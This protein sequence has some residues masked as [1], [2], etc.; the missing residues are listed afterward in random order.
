[1]YVS[2]PFFSAPLKAP[3]QG[4]Q[5]PF[6]SGAKSTSSGTR[7]SRAA[8]AQARRSASKSPFATRLNG[9][10]GSTCPSFHSDRGMSRMNGSAPVSRTDSTAS[11]G[12][13]M[14]WNQLSEK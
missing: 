6:I 2:G 9:Y 13:R 7:E 1:M 10:F 8:F 14:P 3:L 4:N 5:L 11:A 12:K